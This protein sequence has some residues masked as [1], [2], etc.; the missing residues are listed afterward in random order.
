MH[1][2]LR[3]GIFVEVLSADAW[4]EGAA[5]L[6]TLME[7]DN[8]DQATCM[9]DHEIHQLE[10]IHQ[11]IQAASPGP[12]EALW[13]SVWRQL[14]ASAGAFAEDDCI[15]MYNFALSISP[16][17]LAAVKGSIFIA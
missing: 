14:E 8:L 2:A 12:G 1:D 10:K 4:K 11:A 3:D 7:S 17:H 6:R 13:P 5:S 15:H 16:E 9:A